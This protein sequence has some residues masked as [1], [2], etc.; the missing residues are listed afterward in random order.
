VRCAV[1]R[2][3]EAR[4]ATDDPR[5]FLKWA[6]GKGQLL[7]QLRPLLPRTP[8]R[9]YFEPFVGSAALFFALRPAEATLSDVNRE[10]VDCYL[11]V[12]KHVEPLVRALQE[13]EYDEELYYQVREQDPAGLEL[14]Q[15]AARTI[16]L[17][18]TGYNGLYRVNKSGRFNV[19][20]GR[21][22]NPGFRSADSLENLRA[23]SR[24]LQSA[25]IAVRDFGQVVRHA[26]KGD[27]VYFDPPYVPLSDT[28]DFTSYAAGGFGP[29]EQQR[30]AEIVDELSA[31]GVL[32]M[33]SNS[34]TPAVRA[35]YQRYRIDV[36]T[37]SRSI[38][39]RANGRG[40][41]REVVVRNYAG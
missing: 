9:R 39:S 8:W 6:G 12:Q 11:A 35:L 22:T 34:D 25:K 15:R 3:S 28:A 36:V 1:Q 20:F 40:K 33:L 27:F 21:Y 24:A 16:Y 30:L 41:V 14:P 23:C 31:A 18:K 4:A 7:D 2:R 38:N 32:V 17:N 10:L 29:T 13:H 26:R 37:A 19:P 5:P